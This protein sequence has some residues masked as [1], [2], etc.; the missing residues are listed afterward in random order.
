M[1]Y[2]LNPYLDTFQGDFQNYSDTTTKCIIKDLL[3]HLLGH[4]HSEWKTVIRKLHG[5]SNKISLG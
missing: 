2:I 1:L 4:L 5:I 3:K